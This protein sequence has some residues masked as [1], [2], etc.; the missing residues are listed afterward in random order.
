VEKIEEMLEKTS[1][2]KKILLLG[3]FIASSILAL[4]LLYNYEEMG[5]QFLPV[6]L[7]AGSIILVVTLPPLY[8]VLI[9]EKKLM[10]DLINGARI[11]KT[12]TLSKK[13]ITHL[14]NSV[15][16]LFT[17]SKRI[18]F[19]DDY[20][21]YESADPGMQFDVYTTPKYELVLEIRA[22]N[23]LKENMDFV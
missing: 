14:A 8:F 10:D 22:H 23:S 16:Y 2:N 12:L 20:E 21:T 3:F 9:S 11:L 19:V 13:E 6:C 15:Q 4:F 17:F 1:S 5:S 7:T 18:V